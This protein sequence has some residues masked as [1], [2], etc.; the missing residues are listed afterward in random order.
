MKQIYIALLVFTFFF[1]GCKKDTSPTLSG[2]VTINNIL[3]LKGDK[4]F[5]NGLSVPTGKKITFS[6]PPTNVVTILADKDVNNNVRKIYF[7]TNNIEDSYSRVGN[8]PDAVSASIAFE[9]LITFTPPLWTPLGDS[10]KANQVWLFKTSFD[11]YAKI[12]V[13]STV[14]EKRD[15]KPYAECTFEWVYQPD[16]STT[17]P[18]K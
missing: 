5:A 18:V 17:F 11:K 6:A 1:S 3:V 7:S 10:V 9:N 4:Y 15:N 8:Y 2:T 12:R 16:G 14:A 13:I